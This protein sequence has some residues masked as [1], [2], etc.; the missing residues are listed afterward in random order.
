MICCDIN[1]FDYN[2]AI[3][4]NNGETTAVLAIVPTNNLAEALI[5]CY[6]KE[7]DETIIHLYGAESY[8]QG[9]AQNMYK[10]AA[11][12]YGINDFIVEVN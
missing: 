1:L 6:S 12:Q 9:L 5:D 10:Y 8:I 4:K 7:K 3:L 11:S 2:Q